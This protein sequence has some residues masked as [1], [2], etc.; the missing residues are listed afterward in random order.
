VADLAV[1]SSAHYAGGRL[2]A[3]AAVSVRGGRAAV[4]GAF[5]T[6]A[7]R[8]HATAQASVRGASIAAEGRLDGDAVDA[9]ASIEADDLA[10]AARALTRDFGLPPIAIAGHGRVDVSC[11]GTVA[12]PSL[13]VAARFPRLAVGD[14]AARDLTASARVPD[15]RA[16]DALDADVRASA[17]D[18]GGRKL[19]S[20][21]VTLR[22][23]GRHIAAQAAVAAPQPLRIELAG[24]R[25]GGRNGRVIAIDGFSLRYP[26]ATWTLRRRA[27]LE[28]GGGAIALS[29]FELGAD[30]QRLS[31]DLRLAG[32]RRTARVTISRLDLARLPPALVPREVGL[33]GT[34]DAELDLRAGA[35]PGASPRLVAR[36]A[37]TGGRLHGHRDLSLDVSG[38]LER[39]RARGELHARGLGVAAQAHFDLPGAWP[40]RNPRAPVALTVETGDVD[41]AALAR[42]IAETAGGPPARLAGHARVAVRLDG[43]VGEPRLEVDVSGRGLVVDDRRVG[44]LTL[45]VNGEGDGGL[46]AR[47]T[48]LAPAR[49]RIDVTT[50]LSLRAILRRP[51]TA[52][53]L[54]RTRFEL[55]G[56][57]DRLPLSV[58]AR[59]AGG[60][61]PARLRGTLSSTLSV[62][63]TPSEPEGK[64][65]VD[66][67]GAAGDA[68]PPTD[69]RVEA[70][71]E[72][73]AVAAGGGTVRIRCGRSHLGRH[74]ASC[75]TGSTFATWR[76]TP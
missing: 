75:S 38:R 28:L 16:P 32:A 62:T 34:V 42:A 71:F 48:S 65:A 18:R 61:A 30:A 49:T 54:A 35:D 57:I 36:A 51:P 4:R 12:A 6:A 15:L 31:A 8:G 17:I 73:G 24:E 14:T 13:Q 70:D 27:R 72:R 56:T 7:R 10:R 44:D 66:V 63:G 1:R 29:G 19:R 58:L 2:A 3:D 11:G 33:G 40:P 41:L 69:A 47:L 26:E 74:V 68:F 22:A 59:A 43:R 53:T 20:A 55:R 60:A 64:I 39:G 37:L 50:P 25:Q 46:S 23:T 52:E 21:T 5:D 45:S 9:H 67:A 76:E